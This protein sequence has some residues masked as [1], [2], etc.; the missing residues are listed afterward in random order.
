[1]NKRYWLCGMRADRVEEVSRGR[2]GQI[3]RLG[4]RGDGGR[5]TG[6]P[7]GVIMAALRK[8]SSAG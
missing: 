5:W 3:M 2:D 6:K 1:M 7:V 8:K 4:T